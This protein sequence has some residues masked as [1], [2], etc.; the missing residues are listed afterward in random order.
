MKCRAPIT[1]ALLSV[2]LG[3]CGLYAGVHG[4]GSFPTSGPARGV[5]A[6]QVGGEFL[7]NLG[8]GALQVGWSLEGRA[9]QPV[10]SR[11]ADGTVWAVGG[12]VGGGTATDRRKRAVSFAGRAEFGLP[13]SAPAAERVDWYAGA[14]LSLP[15]W[16]SRT[17]RPEERN[18]TLQ[19]VS[20]SVEL[21]PYLRFRLFLGDVLG[22]DPW[23]DPDL[24]V[25]LSVRIRIGSHLLDL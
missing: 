10:G 16:L 22:P 23:I 2:G 12:H 8:D 7:A 13:I 14:H 5:W 4:G 3:A 9:T 25:G 1:T 21:I 6:S 18:R 24:S 19:F 15:I 11:R 17:E 20:T